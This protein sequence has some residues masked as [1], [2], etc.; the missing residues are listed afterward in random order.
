MSR[1]WRACL[2]LTPAL[3]LGAP[4]V[5]QASFRVC[6]HSSQDLSVAVGYNHEDHGWTSEGWWKIE[7]TKCATVI[8]G[9][10][11]GR[12]YY[13]YATGSRGG[14]W[15]GRKSQEGG[16]FCTMPEAFT[17]HN[18][19]YLKQGNVLDCEARGKKGYRFR[20]VDTGDYTEFTYNLTD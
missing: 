2:A 7:P 19:A 4:P 11:E 10:L 16:F 12:Y 18:K 14:V 20:S 13:V 15:T 17:L 8:K 1:G 6:N 3:L 9:K 5:S